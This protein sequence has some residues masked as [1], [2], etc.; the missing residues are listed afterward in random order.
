MTVTLGVAPMNY[1]TTPLILGLSDLGDI[2]SPSPS[3]LN[4]HGLASLVFLFCSKFARSLCYFTSMSG[5]YLQ[6]LR[7]K[8]AWADW[9]YSFQVYELYEFSV[10]QCRK[11]YEFF[12]YFTATTLSSLKGAE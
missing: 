4:A 3:P 10:S 6:F 9:Q 5:S 8:G 1:V 2:G 11:L 12:L 7:G